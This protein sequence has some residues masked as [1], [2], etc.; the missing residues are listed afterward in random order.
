MG[1]N[2]NIEDCGLHKSKRLMSRRT[3]EIDAGE[4]ER[5]AMEGCDVMVSEQLLICRTTAICKPQVGSVSGIW[6]STSVSLERELQYKLLV[7]LS[8]MGSRGPSQLQIPLEL[9]STAAPA[10]PAAYF[11]MLINNDRRISRSEL[12]DCVCSALPS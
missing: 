2:I 9:L 5:L 7:L 10:A 1:E 11:L 4:E 3:S 6:W 12:I 8:V